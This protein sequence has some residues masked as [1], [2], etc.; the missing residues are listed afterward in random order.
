MRKTSHWERVARGVCVQSRSAWGRQQ[1]GFVS[2]VAARVWRQG[3]V[4]V[5]RS[6]AGG[7]QSRRHA[8]R[9]SW[10]WRWAGGEVLSVRSRG[11]FVAAQPP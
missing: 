11:A 7:R 1:L 5:G 9:Q 6:V 3:Q 2:R 8:G 10:P 4:I